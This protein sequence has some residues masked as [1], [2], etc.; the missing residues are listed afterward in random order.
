MKKSDTPTSGSGGDMLSIQEMGDV[1]LSTF[2][3]FGV[4]MKLDEA[5]SGSRFRH[6]FFKTLKP[7][8]MKK[9]LS[10]E[11]DLKY[12]L[13]VDKVEILAPVPGKN[14]IGVTVPQEVDPLPLMWESL[15]EEPEYVTGKKLTIPIGCDEFGSIYFADISTLPHTLI[16]GTTGSGKSNFLSSTIN[17]LMMKH[18]PERLRFIMIDTKRVDLTQYTDIPHLLAPVITDPKKTILAL[19][20]AAKEM[21]RRLDILQRFS[22]TNISSYH[23]HVVDVKRSKGEEDPEPLPYIIICIDE[24]ADIMCAYPRE[25]ESAMVRLMQMCRAVGIHVIVSTQ[26]PSVN[27]LTGTIK[28]NIPTRIAFQVMSQ[29]D[30][31]TIL[32]MS[33]AETLLGKG[34]MFFLGAEESRPVR[35]QAPYISDEQI[36]ENVE[37]VCEEYPSSIFNDSAKMEDLSQVDLESLF[38]FEEDDDLYED[39]KAAVIKAGKA[40]TSYL[41]RILKIGYSRAARLMDML[42]EKGVIGPAGGSAPR[43]ILKD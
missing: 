5:L 41:Q 13:A 29:I 14:L 23:K 2:K 43:E 15:L 22:H 16:A 36:A 4:E 31:R 32:D 35:L 39:A 18:P 24:I 42:E 10:F 7:V 17:Y 28:A 34:D 6:Y 8:R 27:V 33:G 20:W 9:I 40:S 1:I 25:I 19:K 26:R 21:D 11:D 12:S 38:F 3:D 37:K 30:S